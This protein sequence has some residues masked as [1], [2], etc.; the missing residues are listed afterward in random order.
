MI[1][2]NFNTFTSV[3]NRSSF[4]ANCARSTVIFQDWDKKPTSA[5]IAAMDAIAA[6]ARHYGCDTMTAFVDVFDEDKDALIA[7][8][9][10][11]GAVATWTD[12]RFTKY[13]WPI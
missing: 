12:Q 10:S 13:E 4:F 6:A 7:Y 3:I 2:F 8:F 1:D 11:K 5:A 9:T